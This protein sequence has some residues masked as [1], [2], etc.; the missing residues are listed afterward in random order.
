MDVTHIAQNPNSRYAK[1]VASSEKVPGLC[2]EYGIK[3]QGI[4]RS[5]WK[6]FTCSKLSYSFY[7]S[8]GHFPDYSPPYGGSIPHTC[9]D[10]ST[11]LPTQ[12]NTGGRNC[13]ERIRSVSGP[14]GSWLLVFHRI[15]GPI[16]CV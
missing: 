12:K 4:P 11:S 1:L 3:N 15:E 6:K 10:D 8:L 2:A 5:G 9:F 16:R 13:K 14:S 7:G